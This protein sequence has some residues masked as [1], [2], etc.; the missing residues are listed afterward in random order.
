MAQGKLTIVIEKFLAIY[1]SVY[2]INA[3]CRSYHD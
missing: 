3:G 2:F 1:L